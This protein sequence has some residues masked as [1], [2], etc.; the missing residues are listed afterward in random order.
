MRFVSQLSA[1]G[2]GDKSSSPVGVTMLRLLSG[3]RLLL[4]GVGKRKTGGLLQSVGGFFLPQQLHSTPR[5]SGHL[6][7][8]R[9]REINLSSTY[10]TVQYST[11]KGA[12]KL[13]S[14]AVVLN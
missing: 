14:R 13:I 3:N 6:K 7:K 4:S 12:D 5:R 10:S 2:L 8:G 9:I 1:C 11:Y